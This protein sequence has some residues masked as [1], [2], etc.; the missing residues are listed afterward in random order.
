MIIKVAGTSGSGKSTIVK[1]I[2]GLYKKHKHAIPIME[3]GRR[4]PIGYTML[5][6]TQAGQ[7]LF[8]PGHY[9]SPCGGCDNI[10]T[11]AKLVELI[12]NRH[13]SL[14]GH[15]PETHVL[16][17]GLL[18]SGDF[19]QTLHLFKNVSA[20]MIV[21]GLKI[22]IEDCLE[23]VNERRLHRMGENYTPV[24]PRNTVAKQ[25]CVESSLRKLGDE[26]VKILWLTR[27]EAFNRIRKAL[28]I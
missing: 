6:P 4:K 19:K 12:T 25:K 22:S 14:Q 17:E 28:S 9:E 10:K 5:H 7:Q 11:Y 20:D 16:F 13:F 21:I 2:M 23:S 8:V 3:E 26:G 15:F 1:M 27:N 24:N 18:I